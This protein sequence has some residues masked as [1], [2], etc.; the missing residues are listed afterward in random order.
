MP[1]LN[2]EDFNY[3]YDDLKKMKEKNNYKRF[4][5]V[6]CWKCKK[7]I[8]I[9]IYNNTKYW[10]CICGEQNKLDL[11][12]I[13]SPFI[14]PDFGPGKNKIHTNPTPIREE[15]DAEEDIYGYGRSW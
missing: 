3:S 1:L 12:H 9:P 6:V 2:R 15:L 8:N 5:G 7:K 4:D 13:H 11:F 10:R 14:D